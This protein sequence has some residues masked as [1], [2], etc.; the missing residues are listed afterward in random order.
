MFVAIVIHY[1]MRMRRVMLSSMA[2]PFPLYFSVCSR[3]CWS[4]FKTCVC[5]RSLVGNAG[6]NPSRGM[7]ICLLWVLCVVR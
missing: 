4:W 2:C 5:G 1:A 7:D 6:S 3:K